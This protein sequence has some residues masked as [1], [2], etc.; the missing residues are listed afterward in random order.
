MI[1]FFS[2]KILLT[3]NQLTEENQMPT[4]NCPI[5][6][7]GKI[8][9]RDIK[10][11]GASECVEVWRTL[12][13]SQRAKALETAADYNVI[14][15]DLSQFTTPS[16]PPKEPPPTTPHLSPSTQRDNEFLEKMFGPDAPGIVKNPEEKEK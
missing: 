9:R 12:S 8:V 16:A 5:C 3:P 15:A 10:T 6:H 14:P 11:C 13:P 7:I 2:L 4:R 1:G